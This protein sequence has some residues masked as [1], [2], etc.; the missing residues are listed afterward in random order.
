MPEDEFL[1]ARTHIV[2]LADDTFVINSVRE[3]GGNCQ[4]IPP[5]AVTIGMKDIL[6]ARHVEGLF[7]CGHWQRT[8][9]RRTLFQEPTVEYPGSFLKTHPSFGISIDE[10]T[11]APPEVKPF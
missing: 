2:A 1:A 3:A 7:Y 8:V 10:L 5:F 9:F 6:A 11:A 4:M